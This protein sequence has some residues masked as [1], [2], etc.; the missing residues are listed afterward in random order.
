M[1][2]QVT[3]NTE[4]VFTSHDLRLPLVKRVGLVRSQ[5]ASRI[6]WHAHEHFELLFLLDGATSYEF[7]D[8]R[9]IDLPGGHFLVVRPGVRH[10]GMQ[11]VRQPVRLCGVGFD[12][13]TSRVTRHTPFTVADLRRLHRHCATAD[14][15]AYRMNQELRRLVRTL[16]Q[17]LSSPQEAADDLFAASLR[18]TVCATLLEVAR[19]LQSPRA[20]DANHAVAAALQVMEAR[21]AEPL[22]MAHIASAAHCSRARLFHLFKETT[23]MTPNDYLQRLRVERAKSHLLN[24]DQPITEVALACGFSSSQYF[25]SV[26]RK[27]T[28]STASEFRLLQVPTPK[29][30]SRKQRSP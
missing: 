7:Q 25:S 14:L 6:T 3:T 10:R 11:N 16:I 19:Q 28:S 24:S 5:S 9:A 22:S 18:L 1:P 21:F 15:R 23:G 26:F 30:A 4:Q 17:R 27:Y 29:S 2:T 12:P 20:L 8:G 13:R